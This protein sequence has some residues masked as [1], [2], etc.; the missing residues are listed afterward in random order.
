MRVSFR[1]AVGVLAAVLVTLPVAGC[2]LFGDDGPTPSDI[3]DDYLGAFAEG[4]SA[5]AAGLT[6]SPDS[7]KAL[8]DDIRDGLAPE[9]VAA[10]LADV[11]T[12]EGTATVRFDV[13]WDFGHGRRWEYPGRMELR[14]QDKTWKVHW[15]TTV[16]HPELA[17]Q[18]S[19]ALQNE[20]PELAPVL[21]RDGALVMSPDRVIS[22]LFEPAKAGDAGAVAG[23]LATALSGFD[24]SITQKSIMDGAAKGPEGQPYQVVLLRSSDYEAV[25]PRIYELPGVRFT[26]SPR[27]L[28]AD[29]K[30]A[31]TL[32]PGIRKLVEDE[33]IG[34]AGWRVITTDASGAEVAE[35]Y[36]KP[37][38]PAQAARVTL[39]LGVQNAAQSA[40]AS[41]PTP[42]MIVAMRASTGELLAVAQN[43]VAD[44]QG[45]LALTGRYPP[46]STFKIV[47]AIAGIA[48]GK[49]QPNA[50]VGCPGTLTIQGRVVP[51]NDEFDK[52]VIPLHS[53][54]AFSCNTTF[55]ELATKLGP[56]DLTDTAR[57]MG[58]GA[59][60]VLR[61]ATTVTGSVPPATNV[62]ER[63]EDGFG[64]GK[65]VASPFGMA[66]VASTVASGTMPTPSLLVGSPTE[67]DTPDAEPL[68]PTIRT[69][70][71][72]MMREVTQRT[73][74]LAPYPDIRGKTGTAQ[75]GDGKR[76][77]G[78]YVGFR[79]DLAFAVL[80][81]DANTSAKAVAATARFMS[82]L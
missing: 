64:Q 41:E 31:P 28:P 22:V 39:S 35:L 12:G 9:K 78:W 18:Q 7:A 81:T 47:T 68:D 48:S 6:D 13:A 61:G 1:R 29:K 8:L 11:E 74:V 37:A 24:R 5:A 42:S 65:V 27:L 21:D 54:F 30:L 36:A 57:S 72:A 14:E 77:H 50:K 17:E 56:S 10:K 70:M 26:A 16:V 38:E 80:I 2:G 82:A 79:G 73:P 23:A 15:S 43:P 55:A 34:S 67:S 40:L 53:A 46:G 45:A 71:H 52:G 66:L 69:A 76:A 59:D 25:K 32:L 63:A 60:F 58:L 62:V 51:N 19:I 20:Q 4:D 49:T 3:A 44:K 75:F 33:L